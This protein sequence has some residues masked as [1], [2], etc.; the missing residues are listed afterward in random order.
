MRRLLLAGTAVAAVLAMAP[1]RSAEQ[2]PAII[3]LMTTDIVVDAS[4]LDIRTVHVE[5]SATN[6]AAAMDIGQTSLP[7]RESMQELEVVEAYTLKASGQ[8]LPVSPNAIY[9]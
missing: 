7:Y 5:I 8:K 4:G 6:E 1:A 2:S 9:I 3:K